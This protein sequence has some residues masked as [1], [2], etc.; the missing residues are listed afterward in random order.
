MINN[1]DLINY[2]KLNSVLTELFIKGRKINISLDFITKSYFKIPKDVRLNI[3]HFFSQKFQI[4]Q[5]FKK[6]C[7]IIHQILKLKNSLISI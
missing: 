3:T 6:L 7:E 1:T 2:T 4:K 5:S